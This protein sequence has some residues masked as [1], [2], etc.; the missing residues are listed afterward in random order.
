[1]TT[2]S[3]SSLHVV[4]GGFR[5]GTHARLRANN[6]VVR[7]LQDVHHVPLSSICTISSNASAHH[8]VKLASSPLYNPFWSM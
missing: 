1:M 6:H 3:V 7:V 4:D 8:W 5:S 2:V